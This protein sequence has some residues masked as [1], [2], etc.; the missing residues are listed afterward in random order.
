MVKHWYIFK[1]NFIICIF[2][3]TF[4]SCGFSIPQITS[5]KN[6]FED[7]SP[8]I[9]HLL[10]N[11]NLSGVVRIIMVGCDF[12]ASRSVL[13]SC[14]SRRHLLHI[15]LGM[16]M[17]RSRQRRSPPLNNP[18]KVV[19]PTEPKPQGMVIN[20]S[21]KQLPALKQP[22]IQPGFLSY[23]VFTKE[24]GISGEVRCWVGQKPWLENM[25]CRTESMTAVLNQR[26]LFGCCEMSSNKRID[27]QRQH[28]F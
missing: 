22:E 24:N 11:W 6:L 7:V 19:W 20:D 10:K 21:G 9:C 12:V 15:S 13:L 18:S 8:P 3:G 28:V 4:V 16:N 27:V 25:P 2:E 23:Q 1:H 14:Q 26:G 5:C 17:V